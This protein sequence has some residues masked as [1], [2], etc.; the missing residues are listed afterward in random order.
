MGGGANAMI[1][2]TTT[3]WEAKR[4][5][6]SRMVEDLLRPHFDQADAYRYNS[7]SI[8]VRVIDPRFEGM[9]REKRIDM[10]EV[11]LDQLPPEVQKD[12]VTLFMFAPTELDRTPTTFGEYMQNSEFSDPS[13]SP[14]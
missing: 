4:T 5:A 11:Y 1:K 10:V 13:P 3:P 2:A 12:I 6:E 8:R 9:G 7:A 14:L